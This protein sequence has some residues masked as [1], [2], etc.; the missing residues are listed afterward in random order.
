MRERRK[1]DVRN[2]AAEEKRKRP[3]AGWRQG[4]ASVAHPHESR[5]LA[6]EQEQDRASA[7]PRAICHTIHLLPVAEAHQGLAE[8]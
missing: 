8:A 3:S 5:L 7:L 6:L 2:C 4:E 1:S